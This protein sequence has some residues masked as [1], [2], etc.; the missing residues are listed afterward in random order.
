[1]KLYNKYLTG[2][3]AIASVF[4]VLTGCTYTMKKN[5]ISVLQ[6]GSPF[7]GIPPKTFAFKEFRDARGKVVD[8]YLIF[9]V[10]IHKCKLEQPVTAFIAT[11]IRKELERNGHTCIT[12]SGQSKSDFIV[13]GSVY[14]CW[15]IW[16]EGGT[17]KSVAHVGA[18]IMVS[19]TSSENRVLTKNYE[20]EYG[21]RGGT[22]IWGGGWKSILDQAQLTMLKEFST[23]PDLIAF[24]EK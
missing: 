8:P 24:L 9:Q 5:E 19:S 18:K 10:G 21:S 13:E 15:I 1:M 20:G 14:K 22:R 3:V 16:M 4:F 23:D 2:L 7:K 17:S 6:A 12:Y 11:A